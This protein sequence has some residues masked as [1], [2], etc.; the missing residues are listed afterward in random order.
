MTAI[1]GNRFNVANRLALRLAPP[2]LPLAVLP[3]PPRRAA[4]VPIGHVA[5]GA[6]VGARRA[7]PASPSGT[8]AATRVAASVDVPAGPV[9]PIAFALTAA[10]SLAARAVPE[11]RCGRYGAPRGRDSDPCATGPRCVGHAAHSVA[12]P[13]ADIGRPSTVADTSATAPG[14]AHHDDS[15]GP[16]R[17]A[18]S[19]IAAPNAVPSGGAHRLPNH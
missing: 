12:Q 10:R 15:T 17:G 8:V 9:G 18:V 13:S 5:R 11:A 6:L 2:L 19:P 1:H 7:V 16:T 3:C 14:E 4:P